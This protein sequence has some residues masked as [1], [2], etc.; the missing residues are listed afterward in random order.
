VVKRMC[1]VSLFVVTTNICSFYKYK[2][3]GEK[4]DI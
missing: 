4:K 1:I 3:Y 2:Y